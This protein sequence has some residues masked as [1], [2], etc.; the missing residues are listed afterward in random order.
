MGK[1]FW[2]NVIL[3]VFIVVAGSIMLANMYLTPKGVLA[4]DPEPSSEAA[5]LM[6]KVTLADFK[7]AQGPE[8]MVVG[9]FIVSNMSGKEI[10]NIEVLCTFFDSA[11][12]YLD[13]EK[14][15]LSDRVP[16]GKMLRYS[17]AA[18]RYIHTGS[19]K[20]Q[21]RIVDFQIAKAPVFEVHRVEGGHGAAAPSGGHGE[22]ASTGAGHEP[23]P[24]AGH[25]E[26]DQGHH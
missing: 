20:T 9:E 1:K 21:C 26:A 22:A 7:L 6:D 8:H 16:A 13:Q 4:T 23:A 11:G 25:G 14:W 17:S 5:S 19:Q 15:F 12:K 24:A 2:A 18:K 10:K 3:C